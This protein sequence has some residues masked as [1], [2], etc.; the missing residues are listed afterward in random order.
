MIKKFAWRKSAVRHYGVQKGFTLAELLTAVLVISVIMVALAPVITKRMK[1]SISV[2]T[3]NRKGLEIFTNPGTYTF[4]VPIGINTLFIQGSGGAG[5]GAGSTYVEKDVSF[6]SSSNWTIPAGVNEVTL[7]ITGSG[8]GGGGGN[9]RT[10]SENCVTKTNKFPYLADNGKDLCISEPQNPPNQTSG[11]LI[12]SLQSGQT[13]TT[14]YCCWN[15]AGAQYATSSPMGGLSGDKRTICMYNVANGWCGARV[16]ARGFSQKY[17]VPKASRLMTDTESIRVMT[18][19]RFGPTGLGVCIE[20]WKVRTSGCEKLD[21]VIA[22]LCNHIIRE[23]EGF[24]EEV[25]VVAALLHAVGV[26][27]EVRVLLHAGSLCQQPGKIPI[28]PVRRQMPDCPNLTE[29]K[30]NLLPG[31]DSMLLLFKIKLILP[32]SCRHKRVQTVFKRN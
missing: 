27:P 9:A 13:C 32:M 1:D 4:D 20:Y 7:K 15:N 10:A 6:T 31:Y 22:S 5:G 2:Q 23:L 19:N 26:V 28:Q 30:L 3:D 16:E 8:G 24:F 17:G 12:Y 25:A 21:H 11:V 18:T 14:D 29:E